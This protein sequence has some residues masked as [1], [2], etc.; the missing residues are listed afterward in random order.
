MNLAANKKSLK[1]HGKTLLGNEFT[2]EKLAELI[3]L[4]TTPVVCEPGC[5]I[6]H[7]ISKRLEEIDKVLGNHGVET[8]Y[9]SIKGNGL[10]G[11]YDAKEDEIIDIQCSNAGDPY[12]ATIFYWR[13]KFRIGDWGSI[14]EQLSQ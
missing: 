13:G 2:E 12:A 11:V 3:R 4:C 5:N 7:T 8:I 6:S 1:E 14:V 10:E 9:D